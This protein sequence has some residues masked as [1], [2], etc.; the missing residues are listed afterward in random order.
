MS[1]ASWAFFA[2]GSVCALTYGLLFLQ[3]QPSLWRTLS[4]AGLGA[5]LAL[6]ARFADAPNF[7]ALGLALCAVGDA[8]LARDPKRWL[9]P[10]IVV[11]LVAHLVL[12]ALF[13]EIGDVHRLLSQWGP[14][15]VVVGLSGQLLGY[16]WPRMGPMR[17]AGVAYA[18][19]LAATVISSL[20]LPVNF[21]W[22]P[23]G[24]LLFFASD[25]ILAIRLFRFEGAPHRLWD[26]LVWWLYAGAIAL[27]A[28]GF[29]HG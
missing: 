29:L 11:F 10:G 3:A 16:L 12:T 23:L 13:S 26:H 28:W 6:A 19:T 25:A 24:A 14:V 8:C 20:T 7:L 21:G 2:V 4:K 17:P 18:V 27:I 15:L 5:C 9:Q 22:V 1:Q